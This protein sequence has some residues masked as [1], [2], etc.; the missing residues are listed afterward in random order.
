MLKRLLLAAAASA[1]LAGPANAF[2]LRTHLYIAQHVYDDLADCQVTIRGEAFRVAADSCRAIRDHRGAFL[3]G[4]L[5]PDVFPDLIV[6]QSFVHPGTPGGWQANDWLNHLLQNADAPDEL[7]FAWGYAMHFAGDSFAHSYVNNYAG[8]VFEITSDRTKNI[9]LRHFRLEKYIDQ[10]LDFAIDPAV[11]RVPAQFLSEQ[12]IHYDYSR[13]GGPLGA[14]HF[15]TGLRDPERFQAQ[16]VRRLRTGGPAAPV[17]TILAMIE[18]S[19]AAKVRAPVEERAARAEVDAA[20]AAVR[21][22]EAGHRL[23]RSETMVLDGRS[24]A[25]RDLNAAGRREVEAAY[26]RYR[27]AVEAWRI[28]RALVVFTVGWEADIA[29]AAR[30]YI[31]A[32]LEFA[33]NMVRDSGPGRASYEERESAMMPYRRWLS[34]YGDVLRGVPAA[35]AEL[36]CA[37]MRE[38]RADLSLSRAALLAGLGEQPRSLYFRLLQVSENLSDALTGALIGLARLQ[39]RSF[40][41]LLTDVIDPAPVEPF[42]LNDAFQRGPNGQLVF[43]CVT[44][45]IDADLGMRPPPASPA[46]GDCDGAPRTRAHLDPARFAPLDY[47]LTLARL[48]LLDQAGVRQLTARFGGDPA[49]LRMGAQPRYSLLLDAVRSLDGSQQWQGSSMPFPRRN[50]YRDRGEAASAGYGPGGAAAPFGFPLYRT[51]ALRRTVF[52]A[53]FPRP[54]EGAILRRAEMQA[55]HYP[56]RPCTGDPLRGPNLESVPGLTEIC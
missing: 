12:L 43:R 39:D 21:A 26:A 40:A 24:A 10:H 14:A 20:A 48:A 5:G 50:P 32:S 38:L 3:A 29:L 16:A 53:L 17:M 1:C 8:G 23:P 30:R 45:W 18:I 19:R 34:C 52:A 54:F 49:E 56:F 6:G 33:R 31:E 4:A 51:P 37:R 35:S 27:A 28:A 25:W 55:P 13:G 11:L 36:V 46:D 2:G 42:A 22:V 41:D 44:D 15:D 9:E 7:A 47:A